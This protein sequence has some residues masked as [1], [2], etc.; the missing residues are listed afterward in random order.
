MVDPT[1]APGRGIGRV[2]L[3]TASR[4]DGYYT[5]C[6]LGLQPLADTFQITPRPVHGHQI[7]LPDQL[8]IVLPG[9]DLHERIHPQD[10]D[11]MDW[12]RAAHEGSNRSSPRPATS[13]GMSPYGST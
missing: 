1:T 12:R 7:E 5:R 13:A 9:V 11:R 3:P 10:E 2:D 6:D 8:Q 4:H